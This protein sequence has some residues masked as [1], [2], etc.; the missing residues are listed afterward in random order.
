[1]KKYVLISLFL[2]FFFFGC[3]PKDDRL[4]IHNN[5]SKAIFIN[6]IFIKENAVEGTMVGIR[7]IESNAKKR[8]GKLYSWESEFENAN[9]SIL[10]VVVFNSYN[11]SFEVDDVMVDSLLRV[12][13]FKIKSYSYKELER[14]KWVVK[15]PNDGFKSGAPLKVKKQT[16]EMP[17]D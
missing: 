14:I 12:G 6:V 8:I 1:M 5:S 9:D 15:Y 10:N 17:A 16:K 11:P 3:D 4:E 13:D 7:K 2:V